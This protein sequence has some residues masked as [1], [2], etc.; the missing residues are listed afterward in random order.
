MAGAAKTQPTELTL[1]IAAILRGKQG[2]DNITKQAI[3][4]AVGVGASYI[5]QVLAGKK[6]IDIELL[7]RICIFLGLDLVED[8]IAP[9]DRLTSAR[10]Y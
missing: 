2:R 10:R 3:A 7:D 8:V 9:A 6:Q 5:G 4:N 1:E